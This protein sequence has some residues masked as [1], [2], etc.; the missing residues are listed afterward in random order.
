M[1]RFNRSIFIISNYIL[2][3]FSFIIIYQ[4]RYSWIDF[5]NVEKRVLDLST[6]LL[7]L[8]YSLTIVILNISFKIYEINKI[9]RITESIIL[10]LFISILSIGVFGIYFYFTQTDFARFVFFLGFLVI[11]F[12]LSF[13]NKI[14]FVIIS[15]KKKPYILLYLGSNKNYPLFMT[16]IKKYSKWFPMKTTKILYNE[17]INKLKN[18]IMTHDLL[19][20]DTDQKYKKDYVQILNS[21]EMQGGKIYSL[22]DIFAYFDQSLPAEIIE[23]NHY[24]FFSSYKLDSIYNLYIKR[25][26]DILISS[27]LILLLSPVILITIILIKIT[28]PGKIF[29]NQIRLTKKGKKF[30]MYKFRSMREEKIN[31]KKYKFTK[32]NDNRI[33]FIGKIIRSLR[34]DE[35]PQLINILTG[36]MSLIGPRPEIP[37]M[38]DNIAKKYPLFKKRLLVKPG[39][40]GWAQVKYKY[41]NKIDKMNEK[42]SYDLYYINNLSF[43]FDLKIFLYTI[44]TII[45]KRGAI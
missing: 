41:V 27:F 29:F 30:L 39:L 19:V 28:S 9:S 34:I 17:D 3:F 38:I 20:V 25:I 15:K 23:D 1:F 42:L 22:V 35:I 40:T 13:F 14:L 33:T 18:N 4:I 5:A 31:N 37:E 43:I 12:L 6:I 16:L 2:S 44:E 21:Y 45:F 10:N 8:L 11:P 26:L 24:E 32:E 7:L 36:K